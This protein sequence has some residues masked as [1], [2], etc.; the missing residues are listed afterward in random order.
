[1]YFGLEK[2]RDSG[3]AEVPNS[4]YSVNNIYLDG[5]RIAAVIPSGDARYYLT[6]QV[7]SV[8]VVADDNGLAVSRMEYMPYGE[9]WFE[10]GDTNNAPKYNSQELDT[11]SNFYYYNARHYSQDVARFVTPDTV[12]DGEMDTQGWNRYAYCKGNPI[13]YKDPTGHS[14]AS[15][16]WA[17]SGASGF[18]DKLFGGGEKDASTPSGKDKVTQD[19]VESST[20][21]A[22]NSG[23][24]RLGPIQKEMTDN[25]KTFTWKDSKGEHTYHTTKIGGVNVELTAGVTKESIAQTSENTLSAVRDM[26]KDTKLTSLTISSLARLPDP[27]GS[28]SPHEKGRGVDISAA[29]RGKEKVLFNSR[30]GEKENQ[31][32][33][34]I[35][36]SLLNNKKNVTQVLTP[37]TMNGKPNKWNEAL[38][39]NA[40]PNERKQKN[41]EIQHNNHLHI[42]G[43]P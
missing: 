1:M 36:D 27:Y 2:Q 35:T 38:P 21:K 18:W 22:K 42:S 41:L 17:D 23:T 9:T 30:K 4:V 15:G 40:T 25:Y 39:L 7:D 19:K 24:D 31:L 28:G 8:K 3:G 11:E 5:V 34:D 26:I 33:K 32:S 29:E 37:W 16:S 43:T 13:E 20:G 12:I 10:E 14:G 6:D